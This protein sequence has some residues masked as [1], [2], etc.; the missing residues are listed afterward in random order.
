MEIRRRIR[1]RRVPRVHGER[2]GP[3]PEG[4]ARADEGAGPRSRR[5]EPRREDLG[6]AR[7][8]R[9]ARR[10][11]LVLARARGPHGAG[12]APLRDLRRDDL[13]GHRRRV[14][15]PD[16]L[17]P[18][19]RRLRPLAHPA[20]RE[21]LRRVRERDDPPDRRRLPRRAGDREVR[22]RPAARPPRR[23]RSSASRR[24][25]SATASSSSTPSSRPRSR[26]T[27]R[28]RASSTRSS[29]PSP[30][31]RAR[32]PDEAT[33][34]KMGAYLMFCGMATLSLSSALWLTAMAGNPLGAE[35]GKSLGFNVSFGSW[36]ARLRRPD[37]RLP[38]GPPVPDLQGLS[39][40]GEGDARGARGGAEGARGDGAAEPAREDRRGDVRRHGHAVGARR[41]AQGRPHRRRLP[42]PRH[43]PR[44]GRP[45]AQGHRPA[46]R[47]PRDVHL[48]RDPVRDQR[49]AQHAR[50]HGLDRAAA[51]ARRSAA[52][53]GSRS[54]SSSSSPTSSS[55]TSS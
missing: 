52:C 1:R 47:R 28:A 5:N 9:R 19:R 20:A 12:V 23:E 18:R 16:G 15:D 13:L 43:L 35:I 33:R 40:G 14:S 49:P 34:K 2:R 36:L 25:G 50:L 26:A 30:R 7:R 44:D 24:S 45:D 46:G 42:R 4:D 38:R 29:S 27:R 32:S 55:T 39:A 48:V 21:G 6:C 22:P 31:A 51:R 37:A 53:R 54:T 41:D 10:R 3:G 17:R 11:D 8:H